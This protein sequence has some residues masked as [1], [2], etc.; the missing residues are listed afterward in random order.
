[1]WSSIALDTASAF[2]LIPS[3]SSA[4]RA[5]AAPDPEESP[6]GMEGLHTCAASEAKKVKRLVSPAD[7]VFDNVVVD[8]SL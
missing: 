2:P 7:N 3:A 6:G 5:D 1:M 4:L 8:S